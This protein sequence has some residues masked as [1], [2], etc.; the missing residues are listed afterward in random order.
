MVS[1]TAQSGIGK[2][3]KNATKRDVRGRARL[4][5]LTTRSAKL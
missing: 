4:D 3:P 2:A 5:Q 1:L